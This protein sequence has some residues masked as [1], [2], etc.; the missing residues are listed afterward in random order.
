MIELVL[1]LRRRTGVPRF[2]WDDDYV[3]VEPE[4]DRIIDLEK[5]AVI[6]MQR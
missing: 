5:H 3:F 4:G 1:N 2:D 6:Q